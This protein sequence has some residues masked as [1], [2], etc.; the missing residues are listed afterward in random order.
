MTKF[1]LI[2]QLQNPTKAEK[3]LL[4]EGIRYQEYVIEPKDG[5]MTVFVPLRE[6]EEFEKALQKQTVLLRSDVRRLLRTHRGII[7]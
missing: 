3:P 5:K 4:P 2:K 7:G 1:A 6:T